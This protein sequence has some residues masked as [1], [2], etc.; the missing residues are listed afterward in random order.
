[1]KFLLL[2]IIIK[3]KFLFIIFQI[4]FVKIFLDLFFSSLVFL[5]TV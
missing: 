1:M 3:S 4:K 2:F 5:D